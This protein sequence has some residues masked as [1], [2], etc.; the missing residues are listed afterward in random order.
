MSTQYWEFFFSCLATRTGKDFL[1]VF[2]SVALFFLALFP[3]FTLHP[4]HST[5]FFLCLHDFGIEL[6]TECHGGG[7]GRDWNKMWS[8]RS[9]QVELV[10]TVCL[11]VKLDFS[12]PPSQFWNKKGRQGEPSCGYCPLFPRSANVC[13]GRGRSRAY[14][15]RPLLALISIAKISRPPRRNHFCTLSASL[16]SAVK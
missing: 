12:C 15:R 13:A 2:G 8:R 14:K 9:A 16:P 10:C 3:C 6:L 1:L 11:V 7:P 5:F 4:S